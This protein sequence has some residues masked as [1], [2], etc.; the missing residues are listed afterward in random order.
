MIKPTLRFF[1]LTM[2]VVSMVIGI[3]IFRN[4]SIIA[5]HAGTATIFYSAWIIGGIISMIGALTFAEIGARVPLTGGFFKIFSFSYSPAIAFTLIW[6]YLTVDASACSAVAYAGAQ[7][8]SPVLL[9]ESLQNETGRGILFFTIIAVLFLLNYLGIR[10]GTQTQNLLS[11]IK[12]AII[13]LFCC[14]IFFMKPLSI[15]HLP[16]LKNPDNN[17]FLSLGAALIAVFFSFGGYQNTVNFGGDTKNAQRNIT[18]AIIAGMCIVL[19]LYLAINFVYVQTLGFDRVQQSPLIAADL[20]SALFG[21]AGGTIASVAIFIS[22]MG[23]LN[24]SLLFNPRVLY[25]MAEEGVLPKIF[26]KMNDKR[27]V[28][29]FSLTFFT[30]MVIFFFVVLQKFENLLNYIFLNDTIVLACAAICLFMLRKKQNEAAY[31]GYKMAGYPFLPGIFVLTLFI[32]TANVIISDPKNA[33]FGFI[34]LIAGF[35]LY[36]LVGRKKA[37]TD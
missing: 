22:I 14:A 15:S 28:Q 20:S 4:P 5:N 19:A 18:R 11:S 21:K 16:S 32:V 29:E 13:L 24:A 8:I 30:A 3:G 27:Q 23:W 26:M 34:V 36:Y 1:D 9:P 31:T 37:P 2:I 7:Y 12:I 35:P 6:G 17:V 10:V 33:L 25:A